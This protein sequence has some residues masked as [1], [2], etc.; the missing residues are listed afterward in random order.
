MEYV[1]GPGGPGPGGARVGWSFDREAR[2]PGRARLLL[3]GQLDGW[4]VPKEVAETAELL[5]SELVVR[6][7]AGEDAEDESGRGLLLVD[8]L[9]TNWGTYARKWVGKVVWVTLALD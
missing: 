2:A 6:R 9:A 8:A 4:G 7:T 3:R 5:L 1:Q